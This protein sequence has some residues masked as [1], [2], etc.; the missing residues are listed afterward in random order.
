MSAT[1]PRSTGVAGFLP[2]KEFFTLD[3][4]S[5][6]LFRIGL[7]VMILLDWIE[8]LPDLKRHYSDDGIVPRSVITGMQPISIHLY[9][10]SVWFQAILAGI[11]IVAALC[12]IVGWRTPLACLLSW[13]LLVSVHARNP[14]LMQGG[15]HLIRIIAFWGIF[16]PLGACYSVDAS[17]PGAQ[18]ATRKVLTPASFAYILQ[19][20]MVY[21]FAASWKWAPEWRD[22]GTAIYLALTIEVF[23][24]RFAY[25]LLRFP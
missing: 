15:D 16:L 14:S 11:A 25:L 5:L 20:C 13:F 4:R 6:A 10:G 23:T 18:P 19:L 21:F 1:A 9:H 24:T 17:R 8:R 3:V 7:G 2:V 22:D 12:L